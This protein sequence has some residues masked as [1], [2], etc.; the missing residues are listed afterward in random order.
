MTA[1]LDLERFA[2]VRTLMT[3]GATPGE[4]YAAKTRAEA[5]AQAAGL[6]FGKACAQADAKPSTAAP[7]FK[8]PPASQAETFAA[9]MN[10]VFNTPEARAERAEREVKRQARCRELL[11]QYGTE[12]AV[13][14]DCD[15]E[16]A[17]KQ[18]CLAIITKT[19]VSNGTID[20]LAGWDGPG[21]TMPAIV[22]ETVSAA[23]PLPDTVVGTWA[24]YQHWEKRIDDMTAFAPD[25]DHAPWVRARRYVLEA[26]LDTLPAV[27][28]ADVLARL[29]WME[30][31]N[32]QGWSRD[33]HEDARVLATLRADVERM[34]ESGQTAPG[35]VAPV[36]N[37]SGTAAERRRAVL[38][39]LGS[40]DTCGLSDREI[41]RRV[42]VSPTTVGS[43]RRKAKGP[44][45]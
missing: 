2:K 25:V 8:S 27:D 1:T 29:S 9:A 3:G 12:D 23:F 38:S 40:P 14:A 15:R 19:P 43:L 22:R 6:T 44:R 34:A 24:E 16:A 36:Q 39:M 32:G 10:A 21:S 33:V 45:P 13:F 20:T 7:A 31:V 26:R 18:A 11:E 17:L 42:G 5:L 35:H 28:L 30:C 41:G 4:R 37:G